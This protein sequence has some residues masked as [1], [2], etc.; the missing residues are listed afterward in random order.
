MKSEAASK[1]TV[2]GNI[3]KGPGD[4]DGPEGIAAGDDGW[5]FVSSGDGWIYRTKDKD[6]EPYAEVGGRPLGVAFD[7]QRNL[8]VCESESGSILRVSSKREISLIADRLGRRKI[9]S[10]NFAVFDNEGWLYFTDSGSSTLEVPVNDGAIFRISP[11]GDTELFADGFFLPN[12][13]AI[14]HG[15]QALY[16]AQST[17]DNVLRLTIETDGSLGKSAV[18][19]AGLESIPDGLAFTGSGELLVIAGGTDTVY[20]VGASGQIEVLAA[21]PP[22]STKHLFAAANCAFAGTDL[23]DLYISSLGGFITKLDGPP[24][25]QPLYHQGEKAHPFA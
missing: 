14:R 4:F 19:A 22:P 25:G 12:G 23:D 8:I 9:S 13:L 16:V 3:P 5:L 24:A 17:E 2:V 11:S 7:L 20:Q 21:D 6:V 1:L 10:P 18:F 15:E